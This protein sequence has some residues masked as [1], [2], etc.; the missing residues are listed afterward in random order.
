ME[1]KDI[2][3]AIEGIL[4]ASGEPVS[5]SRLASTFD[6]D[7]PTLEQILRNLAD[8]YQFNRRGIRL[9]RLEDTYQLTTALEYADLI[10]EALAFRKTPPISRAALEVLSIIAYY[11]PTTRAYIEQVRGVDS[12]GSVNTLLDR[13][14]IEECGTLDVPGRPHLLRTTPA[15]LRAFGISSIHELPALVD[16]DNQITMNEYVA[17]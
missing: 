11:Q 3:C 2:E 14:L 15:F 7:L 1:I 17:Q 12:Y 5:L 9:I 10:R 6:I 8:H 4:F 13:G 16:E